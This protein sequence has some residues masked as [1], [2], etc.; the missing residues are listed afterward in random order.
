MNN[1][2]LNAKEA[3]EQSERMDLPIIEKPAELKS[4]LKSLPKDRY[5]IYC[6]EKLHHDNN[7]IK[8]LLF[9]KGKIKK[10]SILVGPEGG[11]SDSEQKLINKTNNVVAVSLGKR[12]LRCDTA[13]IVSL[14]CVKELLN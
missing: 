9:L 2:V 14:F 8:S 6:D 10:W 13:I 1:L 12:L 4:L 11:F 5:L 7:I 3:A